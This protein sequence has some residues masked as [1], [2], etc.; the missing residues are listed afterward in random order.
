MSEPTEQKVQA[1]AA[2]SL[3]RDKMALIVN[4]GASAEQMRAAMSEMVTALDNALALMEAEAQAPHP[5]PHQVQWIVE[6]LEREL[7]RVSQPI[8][9]PDTNGP[10]RF[11]C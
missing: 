9:P 3:V 2:V 8:K 6:N 10:H 1:R 7:H 5:Q 4:Q 11:D